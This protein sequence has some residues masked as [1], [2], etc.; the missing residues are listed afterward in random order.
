NCL[1]VLDVING[2]NNYFFKCSD[3]SNNTNSESYPFTLI[4]T[5][6][7]NIT[8]ISPIGEIY[9]N[10]VSLQVTTSLGAQNGIALCGYTNDLQRRPIEFFETNST[11]HL[12]S[13]TLALGNY[14]YYVLC[15]DVAGNAA[16]ASTTFNIVRDTTAANITFL[17][18]TDSLD[19]RFSEAVTCEFANSTFSYGSGTSAGPSN[20]EHRL[21]LLY[22]RFFVICRDAYGN[23]L[24]VVLHPVANTIEV[25]TF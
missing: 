4:G 13:L 23:D 10:N 20:T 16:N 21:P 12:Q 2:T 9:S 7:L 11:N 17:S 14:N 5:K 18:K 19:V 25:S 8:S 22:V 6:P 15:S 24:R 1:G 3:L